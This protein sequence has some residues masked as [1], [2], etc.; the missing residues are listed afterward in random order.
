MQGAKH[1][2]THR[3]REHLQRRSAPAAGEPNVQVI[4]ERALRHQ[5]GWMSA[6]AFLPPGT[7][8]V[9]NF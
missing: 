8:S 7:T 5:F 3:Y 4:P 2:D 9:A 6:S 1:S